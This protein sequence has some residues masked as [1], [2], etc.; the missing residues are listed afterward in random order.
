VQLEQES[1][2]AT[3][4]PPCP[5]HNS[6]SRRNLD[7]FDAS[8]DDDSE[9]GVSRNQDSKTSHSP[10]YGIKNEKRGPWDQSG[11]SGSKE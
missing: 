3:T 10:R 7:D 4:T 1:S 5:D 2:V 11:C 6:Q 9:G 8:S